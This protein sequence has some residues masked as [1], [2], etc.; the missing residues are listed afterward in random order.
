MKTRRAPTVWMWGLACVPATWLMV[1]ALFVL[2]AR[3][4]LGRWPQPYQPDPK[5]LGFDYHYT[6]LVAG[7]PLMFAS[8]LCAFALTALGD[9]PIG[10]RWTIPFV[11]VVSLAAIV[12]LA[13]ID[14]GRLFTWL[15][16]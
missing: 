6:L 15:G 8:V 1:F 2:R 11:G 13:Q 4:S 12:L 7:M 10:R 14:P 9:R 16:D 3:L 5:D